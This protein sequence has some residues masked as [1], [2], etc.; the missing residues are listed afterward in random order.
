MHMTSS[1]K[2][3]PKSSQRKV[4]IVCL[5]VAVL[6]MVALIMS[7]SHWW[8]KVDSAQVTYDGRLSKRS[9]VCQSRD[10]DLLLLLKESGEFIYIMSHREGKVFLPNITNF[11]VLSKFV[12]EIHKDQGG[13]DLAYTAKSGVN[14]KVIA[15]LRYFEFTSIQG[16][17]VRVVW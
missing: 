9:M 2:K 3:Q 15:G 11:V 17:R 14:P 10:G 4:T 1:H 12:F 5:V 13:V 8:K 16:R 7:S 6:I